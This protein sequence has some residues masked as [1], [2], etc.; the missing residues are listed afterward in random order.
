MQLS[1]NVG[2]TVITS[3]AVSYGSA[4]TQAGLAGALAAAI[5][6]NALIQVFYTT[7]AT[8]FTIQSVATG[9]APN[10][11]TISTAINTT[12]SESSTDT[13]TVTCQQGWILNLSGPNLASTTASTASFSGGTDSTFRTAYDTGIVTA[14]VTINGT[15]YTRQAN[16]SQNSTAVSVITDLYNGFSDQ[17]MNKLLIAG[18]SGNVLTL[19][20]L[21]TGAA[22]NYPFSVAAAT[23]SSDFSAGS[24]SFVITPSGASFVPGQNGTLYDSG[25]ITANLV[26]FSTTPVTKT[27]N[28]G[29]G[30]TSAS[31]AA[32]IAAAFQND[33]FSPVDANAPP[34][35]S[36]ITF[37]A[38]AQGKDGNNYAVSIVESSNHASAFP[39]PSFPS[40]SV[41]LAGGVEPTPSLDPSV[42]LTTTY[43]YNNNQFVIHQ[44]Q[45]T[46]TYVSDGAGRVV[47]S[48]IPETGYQS[49]SAQYTDF[50]AI[51]QIVDPRIIPGTTNHVTTTFGYDSFNRIQNISYNDGTPGA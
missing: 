9:T 10:T 27:V 6:A 25:T 39:T 51:S 23:N 4:S 16:Y 36:T 17:T 41:Q 42:A 43:S 11:D 13:T 18:L 3:Q 28:F 38:R 49:A 5:P 26:G 32:S 44:G 2:G 45:Q 19:T 30:S 46:R 21:A 8:S 14:S 20:S 50:G 7:G 33:S 47:S 34:Q 40:V 22:T 24:T 48:S 15:V 35:S 12:C 1:V 37:K 31:V 29:Q